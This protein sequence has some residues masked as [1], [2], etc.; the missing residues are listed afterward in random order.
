MADQP[1]HPFGELGRRIDRAL[2][3]PA[4]MDE[5]LNDIRNEG[6]LLYNQLSRSFR[7]LRRSMNKTLVELGQRLDET[8][9][10]VLSKARSFFN[11]CLVIEGPETPTLPHTTWVVVTGGGVS[12]PDNDAGLSTG[13][14]MQLVHPRPQ[15]PVDMNQFESMSVSWHMPP[16]PSVDATVDHPDT[17]VENGPTSQCFDSDSTTLNTPDGADG[18][19]E[20][21]MA[22]LWPTDAASL[23]PGSSSVGW[24]DAWSAEGPAMSPTLVDAAASPELPMPVASPTTSEDEL[25][26]VSSTSSSSSSSSGILVDSEDGD[27]DDSEHYY[28]I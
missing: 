25:V 9:S 7:R 12:D 14:E 13:V 26:I 1:E 27:S 15:H 4:V 19:D 20:D 3:D 21:A 10:V 24:P 17:D 23:A 16:P 6:V 8:G 11:D 2:E 28:P 5:L 18:D 22:W